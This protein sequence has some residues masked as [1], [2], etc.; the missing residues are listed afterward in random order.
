MATSRLLVDVIGEWR[1]CEDITSSAGSALAKKPSRKTEKDKRADALQEAI[2]GEVIP[3]LML[4]HSA[5]QETPVLR[6]ARLNKPT[7]TDIAELARLVLE[8]DVK[9]ARAFVDTLI[10]RGVTIEAVF[11]ELLAPAA[12]LLGEMWRLDLCDFTDVTVG[13]SRLQSLL[14]EFSPAFEEE[15]ASEFNGRRILL[16]PALG[17]QHTLGLMIVDEFF[18]RA[19]WDCCTAMPEGQMQ[20]SDCVKREHFDVVGF[21][22]SSD[23]MLGPLHS[24]IKLVRKASLNRKL[25]VIVGGP[26]FLDNPELVSRVGADGMARDGR[27]AVLQLRT[28]F[29]TRPAYRESE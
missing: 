4:S 21:S 6:S 13:L 5:G 7:T 24:A 17:E 16:L 19:G 23:A 20:M 10:Q 2:E 8:H 11:T 28:L 25:L 27:E 9:V 26:V 29:D 3:R 15:V 22:A 14:H 1:A 18:R 12:K